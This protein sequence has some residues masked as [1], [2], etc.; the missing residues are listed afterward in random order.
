MFKKYI[1]LF[2]ILQ[3]FIMFFTNKMNH[4]FKI[5]FTGSFHQVP[6]KLLIE[7]HNNIQKRF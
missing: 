7:W 4:I 6:G 3:M 2:V 5:F 1:L